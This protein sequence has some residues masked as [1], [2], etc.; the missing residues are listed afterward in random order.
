MKRSIIARGAAEPPITTFRSRS[1]AF[2]SAFVAS[3]CWKSI[4]QTVGTPS[5]SVTP[6]SRISAYTLL[7]SSQGPG[8]TSLAPHIAAE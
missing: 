1:S 6:S 8:I 3:T 5:A 2:G 7:P 4:S